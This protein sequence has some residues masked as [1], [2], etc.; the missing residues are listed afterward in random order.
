VAGVRTM[1]LFN[2]D[3]QAR[4]QARRARGLPDRGR[5]S[6]LLTM[7]FGLLGLARRRGGKLAT[8]MEARGFGRP[9]STSPSTWARESKLVRT[10]WIIMAIG[11]LLASL[12]VIISVVSVSWRFLGL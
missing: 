1:S 7:T 4:G 8:A 3:W 12:P 6:H 10:D 5:I 9:I 11:V 2:N